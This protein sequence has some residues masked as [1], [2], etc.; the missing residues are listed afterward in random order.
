MLTTNITHIA[1]QPIT[2]NAPII[3]LL[4]QHLKGNRVAEY[5]LDTSLDVDWVLTIGDI[6]IDLVMSVAGITGNGS[7]DCTKIIDNLFYSKHG[8]DL[9]LSLIYNL[10]VDNALALQGDK[11]ALDRKTQVARNLFFG[12]TG[13]R[14]SV[15]DIHSLYELLCD[16]VKH[17][18]TDLI[19]Y[20]VNKMVFECEGLDNT[21]VKRSFAEL[22]EFQVVWSAKP[23]NKKVTPKQYMQFDRGMWRGSKLNGSIVAIQA[24]V[25]ELK[26]TNKAV[27]L[28]IAE[29]KQKIQAE[30]TTKEL[31]K[32]DAEKNSE[33]L[34]VT[35]DIL[36]MLNAE[37][38]RRLEQVMTNFELIGF[39]NQMVA[40]RLNGFLRGNPVHKIEKLDIY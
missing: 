15:E 11:E 16:I 22:G 6:D 1:G 34:V 8:L 10:M 19:E 30:N 35:G 13:V 25:R 20:D 23:T 7:V 39:L 9:G 21:T 32:V 26:D 37:L 33:V 40:M 14:L 27:Q 18:H 29:L 38:V 31:F 12:G 17:V 28:K 3:A 36:D 5:K 24:K 4:G 2:L